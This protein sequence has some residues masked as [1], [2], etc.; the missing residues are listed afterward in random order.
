MTLT[1]QIITKTP[2]P[3]NTQQ[4]GAVS[5]HKT[6]CS[7]LHCQITLYFP[8]WQAPQDSRLIHMFYEPAFYPEGLLE[9]K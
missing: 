8:S 4:H 6:E 7:L 1:D 5:S 2:N 3:T 9:V